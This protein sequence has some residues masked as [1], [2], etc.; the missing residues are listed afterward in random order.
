LY[1]LSIFPCPTIFS[2]HSDRVW[3][4]SISF[5]IFKAREILNSIQSSGSAG[6]IKR[7]NIIFDRQTTSSCAFTCGKYLTQNN[8]DIGLSGYRMIF[9]RI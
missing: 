5:Q 8:K 3:S 7:N 4:V 1:Q 9:L 2:F 6:K